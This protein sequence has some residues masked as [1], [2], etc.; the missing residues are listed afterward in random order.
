M[1][2]L[3]AI[4]LP[5]A[6][7]FAVAAR[8]ADPSA[9]NKPKPV[10]D[11]LRFANGD[12][13]HG[14]I[15]GCDKAGLH[16]QC[17]F[18]SRP[19]IFYTANLIDI[20]FR[21]RKTP[22]NA[23][24]APF[25]VLL[26]NGDLLPGAVVSLNDKF[27][28]LETWYAG[29][30]AIPRGMIK[31]ITTSGFLFKGP[32]GMDGWVTSPASGNDTAWI[33]KDGVLSNTGYGS[34]G[35]DMKLPE[36]ARIEFDLN[37]LNE[38]VSRV[39]IFLC[40]DKGGRSGNSCL[41][42]FVFNGASQTTDFVRF[43]PDRPNVSIG[44]QTQMNFAATSRHHFDF[45]VSKAAKTISLYQDGKHE[46]TYNHLD[47]LA[48]KG[49]GFIIS[50]ADNVSR[51]EVSKIKVT[52]WNG[53]PDLARDAVAPDED[54]I[55]VAKSGPVRGKLREIANGK[56]VF[57]S[58]QGEVRIPLAEIESI[59]LSSKGA[60]LPKPDANDVQTHLLLHGRVTMQIESWGD[61]GVTAASPDFGNAVFSPEAFRLLQFNPY[62]QRA[63][64]GGNALDNDGDGGDD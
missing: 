56:A 54:S 21:P 63:P 29:R 40:S 13:L 39:N 10:D 33:C 22:V 53:D 25:D 48:M 47:D 6:L 8:G 9:G 58:V 46:A 2:K 27:L 32:T 12:S 7:V 62:N 23:T 59:G 38:G 60:T 35:R 36:P 51:I 45:R 11:V 1:S 5:C 17:A 37:L 14:S 44:Q 61:R 57:T 4:L 3:K 24:K 64:G 42:E 43:W 19:A 31:T 41:F 16:W 28:L 50:P 52:F 20:R 15:A 34:I 26:V 30:L 18:P 49:G 55:K